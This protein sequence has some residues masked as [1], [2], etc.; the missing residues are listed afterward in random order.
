[1]KLIIEAVQKM[2]NGFTTKDSGFNDTNV[3]LWL[4]Y[5]C[6]NQD[7]TAFLEISMLDQ[8]IQACDVMLTP[9]HDDNLDMKWYD[10]LIKN[11][12]RNMFDEYGSPGWN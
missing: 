11:G 5:G 7:A 6:I 10:D 2:L 9:I 4:D 8:I 1:M 12:S 3:Y